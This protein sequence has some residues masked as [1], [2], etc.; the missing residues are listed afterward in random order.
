[1][2]LAEMMAQVYPERVRIG[3]EQR[4]L[5]LERYSIERWGRAW[6]Q[7]LDRVGKA[8]EGAAKVEGNGETA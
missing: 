4:K 2:G 1:M 7:A 6:G 8:K 5:A 3:E